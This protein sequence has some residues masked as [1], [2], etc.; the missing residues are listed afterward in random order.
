MKT[1]VHGLAWAG[2]TALAA[3]IGLFSLRYTLNDLNWAPPELR[4]N[5]AANRIFFVGHALVAS[6]A[7]LIGPWQFVESIRRRYRHIHRGLGRIYL[8]CCLVAGLSAYPIAF[9]TYAGPVAVWGFSGLATGWLVT[10]AFAYAAIR[11]RD[12]ARHREWMIRSYAL[13]LAAITLRAY[14]PVPELFG[15]GHTE[16]YALI[17]W[18]CWLPN[19]LAAEILIWH[20][21]RLAP[22]RI[23]AA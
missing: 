20:G 13:T 7:L 6:V 19:L 18:A 4:A 16:G 9:D 10:G 22:G 11:R 12:I 17:T 3:L 15:I 8:A 23:A 1:R 5:M 2:M 21:R 14:L